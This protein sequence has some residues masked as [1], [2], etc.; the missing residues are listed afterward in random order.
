M[1]DTKIRIIKG[2]SFEKSFT[3]DFAKENIDKVYFTSR[4]LSIQ[5]ELDF[6]TETNTWDVNLQSNETTN[7]R[8][9]TTTY[10]I[11]VNFTGENGK[12]STVVYEAEIQILPKHNYIG[13]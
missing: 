8:E 1:K 10:D 13:E 9:I 2:D 3:V 7:L 12:V 11:T 4:Q 5:K 6:N